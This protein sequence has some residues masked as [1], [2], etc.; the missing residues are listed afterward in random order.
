MNGMAVLTE[1]LICQLTFILT[2]LGDWRYVTKDDIATFGSIA[3]RQGVLSDQGW[4][5]QEWQVPQSFAS[6][7]S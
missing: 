3:K 1:E 7:Q 4:I 5:G 2:A 6:S